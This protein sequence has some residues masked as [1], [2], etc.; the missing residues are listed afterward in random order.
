MSPPASPLLMTTEAV[1]ALQRTAGNRATAKLVQRVGP[2]GS[3][4]DPVELERSRPVGGTVDVE[5]RVR[6]IE[7]LLS[8]P[9]SRAILDDIARLRGDLFFPVK[10]SARSGFH[11]S[12]E[13]WLDRTKNESHWLKS[14]AHEITHL[15]TFLSG[16][17][18]D[19]S[20]MG[21]EEFVNAKMSDEI[22]AHAA[23]YVA[24]LQLGATT[25]PAQG[26]TEFQR[27][28]TRTA[29]LAVRERDWTQVEQLAKTWI[30]QRYRTDPAWRTGNT[31][32][33]YYDYW[34]AAWDRAHAATPA[35]P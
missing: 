15:H 21:R 17:A 5:T 18:A 12:G 7:A 25:A 23:S 31:G 8:A 1:L 6:V 30:E 11:R 33:N 35:A 9:R 14:M 32:E 22:N 2:D 19:I 27:H 13:I 24:L 10:W 28:L 34:G 4:T 3:I 29:P 16:G 26:F 20:A